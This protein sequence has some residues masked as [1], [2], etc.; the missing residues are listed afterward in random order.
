MKFHSD[1][2]PPGIDHFISIYD[3]IKDRMEYDRDPAT[4][5]VFSHDT[6]KKA[7]EESPD[8][9]K[10]HINRVDEIQCDE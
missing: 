3:D 6:Q 1:N 7:D 8:K 9:K 5:R 10:I 4:A 2:N